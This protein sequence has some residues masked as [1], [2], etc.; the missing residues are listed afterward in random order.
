VFA[1]LCLA[2]APAPFPKPARP[3]AEPLLA[4]K[5]DVNWGGTGARIELRRNGT[6]RFDH[7]HNTSAWE[8]SGKCTVAS[9]LTLTLMI[10]QEATD[11]DMT[12]DSVGADVASGKVRQGPKWERAVKL[13]RSGMK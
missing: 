1:V 5:W 3:P 12:F 9:R 11:F 2:F 8:G 10:D 7:A 13:T 4:G 6:G